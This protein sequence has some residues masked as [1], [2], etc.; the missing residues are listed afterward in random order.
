M[1]KT[2]LKM[3]NISKSFSGVQV[4]SNID[5]E[6]KSGE[7]HVLMGENGA[8]KSTLMKILTGV[9]SAS[10]GEIYL[11]DSNGE[12]QLTAVD[13]PKTALSLGISMVFQEFNLMPNMSIAENISIGFEPVKHGIIDFEEMNRTAERMMERVGLNIPVTTEVEKL[14][15]AEKQSVEIAKCLSHNGKI[16]ILDEPTSSL[17][18]KE[19]QNLFS[20]IAD[21]K[22]QGISIVYISHRMEEIFEIGDRITVFRDGRKVGTRPVSEVNE[23]ELI[24]MMVGAEYSEKNSCVAKKD[25]LETAIEVKNIRTSK[26]DVPVSFSAHKGEI[27]G[28]FG[29]VGAGRT[30]LARVLFGIDRCSCGEIIKDGKVLHLKSANDAIKNKIGM[31]PEDRKEYGLITQHDIQNNLTLVKL[32]EL[33]WFLKTAKREEQITD[34]YIKTLSIATKSRN[35][36]VERLSGGNQQKV[37]FAKWTSMDFDIIIL[38]EPTRGVD[39]KAKGEIYEIIRSLANAGKCIIMISSD[40]PEILRVSNRVIVMHDG[41]ITLDAETSSLDKEKILYAALN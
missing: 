17:S 18:E 25:Q 4:L 31:I 38:D 35:Q 29:L 6:L 1:D 2:I 23:N 26:Y 11:A 5:F 37:V 12:L 15:T 24:K 28:I 8:G 10:E 13:N 32:R 14:S 16:L 27:L 30:E 21:L 7:V 40:L 36:I 19:V 41:A 3:S 34:E 33:P 22:A 20:L 39:V 9:Y